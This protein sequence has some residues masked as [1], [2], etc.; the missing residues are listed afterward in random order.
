MHELPSGQAGT[1][2]EKI[3]HYNTRGDPAKPEKDFAVV[4]Y[5]KSPSKGTVEIV[6]VDD[7]HGTAHIHRYYR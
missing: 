7:A 2:R 5:Y 6:K 4:L 1:Y 3:I